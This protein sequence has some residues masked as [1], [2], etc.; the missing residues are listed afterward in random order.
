MAR[1]WTFICWKVK[2][3]LKLKCC[4]V[5]VVHL[6]APWRKIKRSFFLLCLFFK[7]WQYAFMWLYASQW[8]KFILLNLCSVHGVANQ[9]LLEQLQT[10]YL[11]LHSHI[12][13]FLLQGWTKAILLLSCWLISAS[14][15]WVRLL[16]PA[17][18][19]KLFCKWLDSM[20]LLL[21]QWA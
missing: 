13:Y 18:Q 10:H 15:R 16:Y 19:V 7:G 6:W 1:R 14:W 5:D 17:S 21:L 8:L 3:L 2:M 12:K 4:Y 20:A 11:L 9:L